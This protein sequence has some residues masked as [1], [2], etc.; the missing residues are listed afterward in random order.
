MC[1]GIPSSIPSL[2]VPPGFG[3]LWPPSR[4]DVP[5]VALRKKMFGSN[6]SIL[7]EKPRHSVSSD[8]STFRTQV[9]KVRY[10]NVLKDLFDRS[11]Y[12]KNTNCS[13]RL[14]SSGDITNLTLSSNDPLALRSSSS[15]MQ[16][17]ILR[18]IYLFGSM[19]AI[20]LFS[21]FWER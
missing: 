10:E 16:P 2:C 21:I 12:G 14:V 9:I 15:F 3:S 18:G 6:P 19:Q 8:N 4:K 11:R 13:K 20:Y 5:T 17:A 7:K 1:R